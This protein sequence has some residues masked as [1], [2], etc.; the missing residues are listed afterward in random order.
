MV[1]GPKKSISVTSAAFGQSKSQGQPRFKG[2]EVA[3]LD[4]WSAKSLETGLRDGEVGV[5]SLL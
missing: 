4:E 3:P 1:L 2:T 5:G